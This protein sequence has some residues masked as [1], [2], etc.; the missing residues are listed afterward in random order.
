MLFRKTFIIFTSVF[1]PALSADAQLPSAAF[2]AK[3]F[4]PNAF[5]FTDQTEVALNTVATSNSVTLTGTGTRAV[6]AACSG[7]TLEKNASGTWAASVG[8]FKKGDTIRIRLTSAGSSGTAVTASVTVGK[9]ISSVWSVTTIAYTYSWYQ[10]GWGAC[11][12]NSWTY[13]STGGCSA[14]CGPGTQ[15]VS[16]ACNAA[17]NTQT[18]TVYCRR[19]DSAQVDDSFCSGAG[20]KPAAS[21]SCYQTSCSG[22]DPSYSQGCNNGACV[23]CPGQSITVYISAQGSCTDPLAAFTGVS[24]TTVWSYRSNH[25]GCQGGACAVG[26]CGDTP[27][28]GTVSGGSYGTCNNYCAVKADCVGGSWTNFGYTW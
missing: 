23:S 20:V 15:W 11:P 3:D 5:S 18:Q 6:T 16:Y 19:S 26:G 7:C 9:T 10:S 1:W 22:G 24:G 21:Q 2:F 13:S 14:S 17:W 28:Y 8:G 25:Y 4:K 12:L 27:Y